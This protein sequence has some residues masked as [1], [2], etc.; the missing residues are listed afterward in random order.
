MR[1]IS[2]RVM[3]LALAVGVISAPVPSQAEFSQDFSM[4]SPAGFAGM[5]ARSAISYGRLVADIRYDSLEVDPERGALLLRGLA[6][7]GLGA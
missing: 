7:E 3:P 4:F 1:A 5:V 2:I 6:I